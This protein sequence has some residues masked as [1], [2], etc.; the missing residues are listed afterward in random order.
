MKKVFGLFACLLVAM[1]LVSM[2][3]AADLTPR[4]GGKYV[5]W[6]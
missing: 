4:S 5:G 6:K 2:S 3:S 1:G